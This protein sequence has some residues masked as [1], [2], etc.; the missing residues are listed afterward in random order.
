MSVFTKLCT[1]LLISA[2]SLTAQ[3]A[4]PEVQNPDQLPTEATLDVADTR[5]VIQVLYVS[6]TAE[7]KLSDLVSERNPDADLQRYA[8]ELARDHS[9]MI[10]LLETM[11][12]VKSISLED[13]EL[14][15]VAQLTST[16]MEQEMQNLA[17]KPVEEFRP[18]FLEMNIAMHQKTLEM[19][20]KIEQGNTDDA[21]KAA[22]GIFRQLVEKHLSDAQKLQSPSEPAQPA[23]PTQPVE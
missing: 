1:G 12:N 6:N 5:E 11:A 7:I 23:E 10:K 17:A 8:D 18:A 13:N 3:A 2:L 22:I 15:E 20:N 16:K 21:L 19:F 14:S 4:Q 9:F